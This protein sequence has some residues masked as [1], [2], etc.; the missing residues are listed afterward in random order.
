MWHPACA[1]L[2][3]ALVLAPGAAVRSLPSTYTDP[4]PFGYG[5]DCGGGGKI[6]AATKAKVASILDGILKGLTSKKALVQDHGHVAKAPAPVVAAPAPG[7]PAPVRGALQSLLATLQKRGQASAA[8]ALGGML[9][10]EDPDFACKSFGACGAGADHPIDD[11]TKDK[12]ASILE[13][14]IR[15]LGGHK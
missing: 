11:A 2:L 7:L 14:I 4:C 10:S 13:G 6:D 1:A 3:A 5:T 8:K 9:S 12:V 15:N